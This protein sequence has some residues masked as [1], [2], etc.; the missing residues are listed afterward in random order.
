MKISANQAAKCCPIN[1]NPAKLAD[2]LN[3]VLPGYGIDTLQEIAAFLSQCGHESMDFNVFEENLNYSATALHRM[4]PKR[5]PTDEA[6]NSYARNPQ[7]IAN[8]VYADRMGNGSE[9]SG[10]GWKY[11]GRGAIQLTGKNNYAAFAA[12]SKRPIESLMTYL[13]TTEGA[14]ESA[15][16]FWTAHRI[17]DL[18]TKEDV[19]GMTRAINGGTIGLDDRKARWGNCLAVLQQEV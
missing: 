7:K 2:A 4:W 13:T 15:C 14:I 6:A 5:F 11:H 16:W 18:V 12:A 17:N 8:K 3:K 10:D 9:A 19:E 1:K